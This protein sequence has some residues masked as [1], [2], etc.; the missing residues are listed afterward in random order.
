MIWT[1]GLT[2]NAQRPVVSQ[3]GTREKHLGL[4]SGGHDN[5]LYNLARVLAPPTPPVKKDRA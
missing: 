5:L 3:F 1:S 2:A 4:V